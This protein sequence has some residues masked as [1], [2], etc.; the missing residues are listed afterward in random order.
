MVKKISC[1]Q[2]GKRARP[3]RN[4]S[5]GRHSEALLEGERRKEAG[6]KRTQASFQEFGGKGEKSL[7]K[8]ENRGKILTKKRN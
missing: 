1:H 8:K 6:D 7:M 4:S 5:E 3:H 2:A